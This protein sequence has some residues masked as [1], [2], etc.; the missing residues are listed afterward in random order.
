MPQSEAHTHGTDALFADTSF[1]L[2]RSFL[3]MLMSAFAV[4]GAT[5]V[6]LAWYFRMDVSVQGAGIL[7]CATR[8]QVKPA[9]SGIVGQVHAEQGGQ[10][11]AGDRLVT[12]DDREWR[13]RLDEVVGQIAVLRIRADRLHT[14]LEGERLIADDEMRVAAIEAERAA[15]ELRRMRLEHAVGQ[16]AVGALLGWRRQPLEDLVPVRRAQAALEQ[17]R[18]L[19]QLASARRSAHDGREREVEELHLE[20]ERLARERQRLLH[21]IQETVLRAPIDGTVLT[22][23]LSER[24]GDRVEAGETLVEVGNA[25]SWVIKAD[26]DETDIARV[27][28]GHDTR[29]EI[30]AFPHMEYDMLHGKVARIGVRATP[31]GYPVKIALARTVDGGLEPSIQLFEGMTATVRIVVDR[32]RVLELLWREALRG[33]GRINPDALRLPAAGDAA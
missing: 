3:W 19:W 9:V 13:Q 33:L 22:A 30:T 25:D 21:R 16:E 26:I 15:L 5:A 10:V 17:K 14:Q 32:G 8:Q 11:R 23:T 1:A 31:S 18:A 6:A 12:L 2:T 7:T 20:L 27:R 24:R 29:I 4:L 28:I